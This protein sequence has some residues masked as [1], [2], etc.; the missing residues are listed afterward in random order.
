MKLAKIISKINKYNN[1][2][3]NNKYK[4]NKYKNNNNVIKFNKLN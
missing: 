4:N 1:N 2:K 3:N